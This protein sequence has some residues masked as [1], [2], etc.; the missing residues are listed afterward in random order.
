MSDVEDATPANTEFLSSDVLLPS[1]PKQPSS[2]SQSL[3]ASVSVQSSES[4]DRASASSL[5]KDYFMK[6]VAVV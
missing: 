3:E 2:L 4:S 6:K 1:P 5:F